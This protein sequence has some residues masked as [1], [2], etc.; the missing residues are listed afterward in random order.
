MA[1]VPAYHSITVE[2]QV[3]A[4]NLVVCPLLEFFTPS[5]G[6]VRGRDCRSC[7]LCLNFPRYLVEMA[8][9]PKTGAAMSNSSRKLQ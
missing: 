3:A 7:A 1:I 6:V 8:I 2:R 5:H 9:G 4:Q